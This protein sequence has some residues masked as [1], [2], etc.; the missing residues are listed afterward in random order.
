MGIQ[1]SQL[2]VYNHWIS[3][4]IL[5]N[6]HHTI[7]WRCASL[8]LSN[9]WHDRKRSAKWAIIMHCL[10]SSYT[11]TSHY[12]EWTLLEHSFFQHC[13]I[14]PKVHHILNIT[15]NA[16][17]WRWASLKLSNEWHDRKRSAKWTKI[18][19]FLRAVVWILPK[20]LLPTTWNKR[21]QNTLTSSIV[22]I[23]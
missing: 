1:L 16:I 7:A 13:K 9:E 23:F 12:L 15:H 5:N 4:Y 11:F 14:F 21:C 17:A 19:H 6:T 22:N 2:W 8:K 20:R 3:H 18:K 10:N